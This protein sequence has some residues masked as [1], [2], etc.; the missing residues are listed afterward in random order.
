MKKIFFLIVTLAIQVS[1]YSYTWIPYG[2]ENIIVNN[3]CFG[4]GSSGGVICTDDG[5][6][7]YD[8]YT[9]LWN[10]YTYGGLPFW[11]AANFNATKILIIM[12]DGSWSDGI[13]TFDLVTHEFEP[14]EWIVNPKF[15]KYHELS[16]TWFA[17]FNN[18]G[19]AFCGLYKSTDGLNWEEV[20][21]FSDAPGTCMDF[22]EEHLVISSVSNI[23]DIY[24]SDDSGN[25]WNQSPAGAPI[26][27][28]MKFNNEG[29]LYGIFPDGSNSSGLW[30]S[31]DYGNSWEVEFWL[32]MMSAVGFD[33]MNTI[34]VGWEE[35]FAGYEG[36]AV[37]DPIAPPPGF[38]FLNEGLPDLTIN[39]IL[40]NPAMSAIAIFCCTNA[41]VY[42]SYDYMVGE[43]TAG[44]YKPEITL[45]PNPADDYINI[46]LDFSQIIKNEIAIKIINLNGELIERKTLNRNSNN[47]RHRLNL[48]NY[49]AGVYYC[50]IE[51]E[52]INVAEKFVLVK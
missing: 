52:E 48:Y 10:L 46:Q 36:I 29:V 6:Y 45:S 25:T 44:E 2:P 20:P 13:Y 15:L 41:G 38:T 14:V 50:V 21:F 31:D 8:D 51:N 35:P 33:A 19:T 24:W 40:I 47:F 28:D 27:T 23:Y 17:G 7:I 32:N 39:K 12:G 3:V 42:M 22:Y 5:M 9:Q 26:I 34:F 30:R 1:T 37:Y 16:G 49:S 11:E 43:N 18:P 4:V